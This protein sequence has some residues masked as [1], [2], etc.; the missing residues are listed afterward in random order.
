MECGKNLDLVVGRNK[1][2]TAAE[3]PSTEYATTSKGNNL[4]VGLDFPASPGKNLKKYL[5]K[6]ERLKYDKN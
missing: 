6:F 1:N 5:G 3:H 2:K 4:F